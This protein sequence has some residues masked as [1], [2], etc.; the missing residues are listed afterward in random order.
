MRV[1][2]DRQYTFFLF[3]IVLFEFWILCVRSTENINKS[4]FLDVF[5]DNGPFMLRFFIYL[6]A[7]IAAERVRERK[8]K[9]NGILFVMQMCVLP[10]I[11]M[12]II[13]NGH[14]MKWNAKPKKKH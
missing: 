13:V 9:L 12:M 1:S 11:A 14:R 5:R 8:K 10:L 2:R 4:L 3:R 7:F 6:F